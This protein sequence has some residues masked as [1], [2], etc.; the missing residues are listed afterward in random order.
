MNQAQV[1]S[2]AINKSKKEKKEKDSKKSSGNGYGTR[3]F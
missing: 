3:S 1:W 2:L